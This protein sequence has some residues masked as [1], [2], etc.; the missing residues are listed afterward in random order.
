MRPIARIAAPVAVM[1][2]C[3]AGAA[4][5]QRHETRAVSGFHAVALSAPIDVEL[6]QGDTESLVLEGDDAAISDI[7]T[8]VED[9]TLKIHKK[10]HFDWPNRTKVLAH[11]TAKNIDGLATKG[12]G[13]IKAAALKCPGLKVSIAGSGDVRIDALAATQLE[14]S[15]AGSGDMMVGGKVDEVHTSIAGSGDMKAGKL[16]TRVAKISI[17]GS[18]DAM[19]WARETISVNIVG[20]GDVRYY[21]DPRVSTS[22]L[23]SGSVKRIGASPS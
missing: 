8:Y 18:G 15:I 3:I 13:D 11:V 10:S 6:V 19:L 21:G 20:S 17:A 2:A 14:V 7:E 5:A 12:S 4:A 9:G 1:L 23:G 16:E 22:V